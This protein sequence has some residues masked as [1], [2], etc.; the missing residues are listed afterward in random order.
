MCA[1]AQGRSKLQEAIIDGNTAEAT[2]LIAA[3]NADDAAHPF[4]LYLALQA[5]HSPLQVDDRWVESGGC[6]AA[7]RTAAGA[8]PAEG[9]SPGS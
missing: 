8:A 1:R 7:R 3:H 9:P 4:F 6:E 5:V 2:R